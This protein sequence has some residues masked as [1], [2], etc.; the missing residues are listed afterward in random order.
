MNLQKNNQDR[1][2]LIVGG[3]HG[4]GLHLTN[5]LVNAEQSVH[6]VG[7]REKPKFESHS[8]RLVYHRC[9]LGSATDVDRLVDELRQEQTG[10]AAIV[11]MQRYRGSQPDWSEEMEVC[12]TAT[13]RMIDTA[14]EFMHDVDGAAIAVVGSVAEDYVFPDQAASYHVA[15]AGLRQLVRYYAVKLGPL[16]IR[17]NLVVPA[18]I[19]KDE[20][21]PFYESHPELLS[22]KAKASPLGRM[23]TPEDVANAICFLCSAEAG[24]ITGQELVVDGGMSLLGHEY[25]LAQAAASQT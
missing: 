11:F 21:R 5:T 4:T 18:T 17:V 6:V 13:R 8:E 2:W 7:R 12:L 23:G 25:A 24:F 1:R 15:K 3:S 16:G 20:A 19:L 10:F 9:D 22:R 14:P